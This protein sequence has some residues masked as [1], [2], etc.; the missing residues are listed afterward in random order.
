MIKKYVFGK[1]YDVKEDFIYVSSLITETHTQFDSED[2]CIVNR[3]NPAIKGDWKYD[4]ISIVTKEKYAQG[5]RFSTKCTFEHYGA[6]LLVFTDDVTARDGRN[7]YGVPF[8]VVA[9]D[10]GVNIWHIM[11]TDEENSELP[12]KVKL[13]GQLQFPIAD[14]TPVDLSARVENGTVY[15]EINGK[16]VS[17]THPDI[18]QAFHVGVTACE[19]IN[20]FYH[21]E[22]E[23]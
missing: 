12:I 5:V 15:V 17:A 2:D 11:P 9:Y 20:R 22:I 21:L 18:P 16:T 7:Y 3:Y 1:G 6:P 8:E 14:G 13:I 10:E 23:E 4:Y 19:G